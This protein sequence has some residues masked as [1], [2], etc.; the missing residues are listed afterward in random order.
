M[1]S[2]ERKKHQNAVHLNIFSP[3]C[4][5]YQ[6]ADPAEKLPASSLC[7]LQDGRRGHL[8]IMEEATVNSSPSPPNFPK[9]G[10]FIIILHSV[11]NM[12]F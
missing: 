4:C 6:E 7:H 11:I 8:K 5:W 9:Y 2:I 1:L 3:P 12:H 10:Q